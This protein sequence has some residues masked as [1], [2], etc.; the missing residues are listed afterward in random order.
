M[1]NYKIEISYDGSNFSGY[2]KQGNIDNTIESTLTKAISNFIKEDI[3]II[4]SGRTDR[5][6][7]ALMQVC[8]FKTSKD[9]NTNTFAKDINQI[10]NRDIAVNNIMEVDENFHSRYLVHNKTYLYRI[11]KK[12][13]PFTRKYSYYYDKKININKMKEASRYLIGT[14]DFFG[15][16]SLKNQK[17]NTTRTINSINIVED[18]DEIKIYINGN[19]FLY[20]SVRIIVG[21]L[22]E[23]SEGKKEIDII[24]KIFNNKERAYGGRTIPPHGL[25]L[26]EVNYKS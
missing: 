26:V 3:E 23:I 22:L 4:S 8:N 15:F 5:G 12:H 14:H 9:I 25:F 1:K 11:S 21:T 7:H 18:E 19:G 16:S 10:L 2:Q 17:K 20:N 24:D 13:N 6:V